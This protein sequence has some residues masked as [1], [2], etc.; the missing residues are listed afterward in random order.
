MS[1]INLI[2]SNAIG[3]ARGD[4]T[5][6]AAQ[7]AD[8]ISRAF[9]QWAT[10]GNKTAFLNGIAA[11]KAWKSDLGAAVGKVVDTFYRDATM[12]HD[13]KTVPTADDLAAVEV[14]ILAAVEGCYAA[15]AARKD[16]K[17]AEGKAKREAAKLAGEAA[18]KA[19]ATKEADD[20]IRLTGE[21]RQVRTM[22]SSTIDERDAAVAA[23]AAA[24]SRIAELEALLAAAQVAPAAR[25][26]PA[27][28]AA[29]HG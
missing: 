25:K 26:A 4:A 5:A 9:Y 29:M 7:I 19:A 12:L 17:K 18:E 27:K 21:V 13:M 15:E 16:A 8:G 3:A 24:Q 23:L 6:C 10:H 2:L 11:A 1:N 28:K 22:L 14:R 20:V